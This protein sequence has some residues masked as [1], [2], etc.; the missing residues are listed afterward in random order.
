MWRRLRKLTRARGVAALASCSVVWGCSPKADVRPA[1]LVVIDTNAPVPDLLN[2]ETELSAQAAVDTVRIEVLRESGAVADSLDVVAPNAENW[3]VSFGIAAP[4]TAGTTAVVRVR[5]FIASLAVVSDVDGGRELD[6]RPEITIDRLIE[7]PF[8]ASGEKTVRVV[9][10][11][12][13]MG[14]APNFLVPRQTCVSSTKTSVLATGGVEVLGEAPKST[15]I[16]TWS[17]AH[18]SPCR[19]AETKG[20]LC[21]AGGFGV[22]GDPT[23]S[24]LAADSS[25]PSD[26]LNSVPLRPVQ[27]S[28]F[29]MDETEFTVGRFRTLWN[30]GKLGTA[31]PEQ[32]T[33]DQSFQSFCTWPAH[34]AGVAPDAGNDA[35]P[36]NCIGYDLAR[37]ACQAEG[38]DLPSEAQWEYAARG[39]GA[40]YDFPWG[41]SDPPCCSSSLS[42]VSSDG[43][44]AECTGRGVEPAGS[45]PIS[46][47]CDPNGDAHGDVSRDGILDLGGSLSEVTRD[48]ARAYDAAC[49]HSDGIAE[50]PVCVDSTTVQ[51]IERG[52]SWDAGTFNAHAALRRVASTTIGSATSGFR[53]TYEDT[54]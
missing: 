52:G 40:G 3:P 13:C 51:R 12:G 4:P 2:T 48:A 28:P 44:P 30:S 49:W 7:V 36:L 8:P 24:A 21:V 42:R 54:P 47:S 35:L 16:G 10:D 33:A 15:S 53:C 29:F 19:A 17:G 20:R 46:A 43:T 1:L 9:L 38:G 27:L 25:H 6:P 22:L 18:P 5:A 41:Y 23:M 50:D 34:A 11:E 26:H 32:A 14:R 45:H 39:R 37:A 31:E